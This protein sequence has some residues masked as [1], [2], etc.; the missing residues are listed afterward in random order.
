MND[1]S[2][3]DAKRGPDVGDAQNNIYFITG[4][5]GPRILE[6][7]SWTDSHDLNMRTHSDP[8]RFRSLSFAFSLSLS[9]CLSLFLSLSFAISTH[10][11]STRDLCCLPRLVP[12]CQRALVGSDPELML[13][14][15][16]SLRACARP[17]RDWQRRNHP[18]NAGSELRQ[19]AKLK[20]RGRRSSFVRGVG[21]SLHRLAIPKPIP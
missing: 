4:F 1:V 8:S 13:L 19:K 14:V 6:S 2:P 21:L 16:L 17:R 12:N 9:L 11:Y 5:V 10:L 20:L 18:T 15:T 3:G 7:L